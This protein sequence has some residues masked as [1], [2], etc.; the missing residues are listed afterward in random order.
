MEISKIEKDSLHH[1]QLAETLK[2]QNPENP[3]L[4]FFSSKY[5]SQARLL[6]NSRE[7]LSLRK[8]TLTLTRLQ[9]GF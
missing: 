7:T 1:F 9:I 2:F 5:I 4:R 8:L 3:A 6:I